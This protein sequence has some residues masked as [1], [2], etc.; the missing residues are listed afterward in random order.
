MKQIKEILFS[1]K[2]MKL[3]NLLFILSLLIRNSG[4][5]FAAYLVWI[6]YLAFGIKNTQFKAVKVTNSIFMIFA[7]IMIAA[8]VCAWLNWI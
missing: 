3:V 5:I 4:I 1:E 6:V 8:N 7:I 2:C